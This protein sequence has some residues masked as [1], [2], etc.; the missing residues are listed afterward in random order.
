MKL[1]VAT[2]NPHKLVEIQAV[3]SGLGIQVE[4]LPP[5]PA[6]D[7]PEEDGERFIDNARLKARYYAKRLGMACLADD[8]GLEVDI[9]DGAPG[10]RSARYAGDEGRRSERDPRNNQKLLK[11]LAGVRADRRT[12]RFV[13]ALCVARADGTILGESEGFFEGSIAFS[14]QGENGFGYDP[15]FWVPEYGCTS[16][17]LSPDEKNRLSHRGQALRLLKPQLADYMD[18][19]SG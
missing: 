3:L 2:G 17:E 13:C 12:A 9:L 19:L 18:G 8:S 5:V 4:G 1:I 11:E 16:A 10:V 15:L 6:I 7:E 14:E